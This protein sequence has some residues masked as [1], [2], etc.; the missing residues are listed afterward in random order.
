M[1]VPPVTVPF[2][3][4]IELSVSVVQVVK[5]GEPDEHGISLAR[6]RSPLGSAFSRSCACSGAVLPY[7]LWE[8]ID[9]YDLYSPGTDVWVRTISPGDNSPLPEGAVLLASHTVVC[10]SD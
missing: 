6:R 3:G 8:T 7:G 1:T 9:Q 5:G 10:G 2:P 4:G